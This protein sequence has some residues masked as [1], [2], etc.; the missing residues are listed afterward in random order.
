MAH[1]MLLLHGK[2]KTEAFLC[3]YIS[4]RIIAMAIKRRRSVNK[5]QGMMFKKKLSAKENQMRDKCKSICMC[6]CLS[7]HVTSKWSAAFIL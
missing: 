1:C 7:A 2:L 6:V 3:F 5:P 4:K